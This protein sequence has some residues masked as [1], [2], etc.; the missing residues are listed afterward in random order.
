MSKQQKI[1]DH[2]EDNPEYNVRIERLPNGKNV[3]IWKNDLTPPHIEMTENELL[4]T[5]QKQHERETTS[6]GHENFNPTQIITKINN[7]LND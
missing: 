5:K 6:E 3:I 1:I 4:Y 2:Y 7:F